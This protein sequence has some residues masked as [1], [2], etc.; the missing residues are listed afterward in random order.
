MLIL[1]IKAP[2][3]GF[4]ISKLASAENESANLDWLDDLRRNAVNVFMVGIDKG[5]E[6]DNAMGRRPVATVDRRTIP[7]KA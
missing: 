2:R 7:A 1:V 6:N 4:N 3:R 5:I